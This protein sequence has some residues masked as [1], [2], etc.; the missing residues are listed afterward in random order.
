M[1]LIDFQVIQLFKTFLLNYRTGRNNRIDT[2]GT[3]FSRFTP[4]PILHEADLNKNPKHLLRE[5][6][7]RISDAHTGDL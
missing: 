5:P 6:S 7:Q 1:L 2:L 4:K 3:T